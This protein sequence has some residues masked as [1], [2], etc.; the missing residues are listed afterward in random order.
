MLTPMKLRI[1]K[2]SKTAIR[3]CVSFWRSKRAEI[4]WTEKQNKNTVAGHCVY[5]SADTVVVVVRDFC[6]KYTMWRSA[7]ATLFQLHTL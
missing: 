5:R 3:S 4:R 6:R 2:H 7:P 1:T